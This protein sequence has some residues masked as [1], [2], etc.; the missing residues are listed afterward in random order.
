[1]TELGV[2]KASRRAPH[3]WTRF[4]F[5]RVTSNLNTKA[6]ILFLFL[7]SFSWRIYCLFSG[8]TP[9]EAQPKNS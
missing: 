5:H 3:E 2:F 9:I 8:D 1:M 4:C 6:Q 7:P